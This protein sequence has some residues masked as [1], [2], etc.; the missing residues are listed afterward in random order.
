MT[1]RGRRSMPLPRHV[2]HGYS[3]MLPLP[4]HE[5]H[6]EDIA[7]G[8]WL[9]ATDPRPPHALHIFGDVPGRAPEPVHDEHTASA[10]RCNDVV[11][12]CAAS[13]KERF[14]VDSIS[15]P[16]CG[17]TPLAPPRR[18]RP[19][20][21]C[22]RMSPKSAPPVSKPMP[23]PGKPADGPMRRTSSYSARF[24]ASPTTSYAAE[25]SLNFSSASLL[26]GLV[27]G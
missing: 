26:P 27:S 25:M 23:P 4:P 21:I 2:L 18:P 24:A 19:P 22:P 15:A 7:N 20:N 9:F 11:R 3:M 17:P 1:S 10:V 8:P 16:R 13:S 14:N 5:R 6:G 12:P